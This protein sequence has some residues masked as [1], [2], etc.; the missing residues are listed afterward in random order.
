MREVSFTGTVIHSARTA[1]GGAGLPVTAGSSNRGTRLFAAEPSGGHAA[2][3]YPG[4]HATTRRPTART[5]Y[6]QEREQE[7]TASILYGRRKMQY[8]QHA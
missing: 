4:R 8:G 3:H 6:R 1:G 7:L 5:P 2:G